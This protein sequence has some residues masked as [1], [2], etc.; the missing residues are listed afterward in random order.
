MQDIG[1]I[2][3][4]G[5]SCGKIIQHLDFQADA[6]TQQTDCRAAYQK[7]IKSQS[8][9]VELQRLASRF[10]A[11]KI[12]VSFDYTTFNLKYLVLSYTH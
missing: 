9:H 4:E 6:R 3:L 2:A 12:P 7:D 5:G 11:S 8:V 1:I 10:H